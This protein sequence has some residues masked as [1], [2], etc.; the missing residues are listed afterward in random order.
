MQ[1]LSFCDWWFFFFPTWHNVKVHSCCH[2]IPSFLRIIF[3]CIHTHTHIYI[4]TDPYTYIPHFP[5]SS[6]P[7][8]RHLSCIHILAVVNTS[9]TNV[10]ALTA[11]QD[12][13]FNFLCKYPQDWAS[14]VAQLVKNPPAMRE[15]QVRSL[16]GDDLL[17][18]EMA[19]HST[20]IA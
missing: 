19:T 12:P 20:I 3:H 6:S 5:Y 7:I 18:N 14:L 13:D 11:L 17:E 4:H 2:R 1:G 16:G 9:T 8:H 10:V 15:T